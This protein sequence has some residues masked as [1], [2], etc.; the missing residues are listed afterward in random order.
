MSPGLGIQEPHRPVAAGRQECVP[1][2]V[3]GQDS[4]LPRVFTQLG[5]D[6]TFG[7][8]PH[9]HGAGVTSR[10]HPQ[11]LRV[12]SDGGDRVC[13]ARA[14]LGIDLHV[15][16]QIPEPRPMIPACQQEGPTVAAEGGLADG[17]LQRLEEADVL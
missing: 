3:E 13:V 1:G 14:E 17:G 10:H 6:P 16:F 15:P 11:A 4:D 2:A 7:R 8:V 12:E 5:Q 9:A